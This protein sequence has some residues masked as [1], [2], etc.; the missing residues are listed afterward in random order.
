[1]KTNQSLSH[2]FQPDVQNREQAKTIK[3][4]S[5]GKEEFRAKSEAKINLLLPTKIIKKM[6]FN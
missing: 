4:V 1:M 2:F 5:Q 3:P 6:S